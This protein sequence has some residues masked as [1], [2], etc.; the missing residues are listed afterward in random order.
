MIK[1]TRRAGEA[2]M[3]GNNVN[4]S[5]LKVNGD[6]VEIGIDAKRN[7]GVLGRD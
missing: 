6:Q 3:I 2:V 7:S 4:I 1:L 5:I